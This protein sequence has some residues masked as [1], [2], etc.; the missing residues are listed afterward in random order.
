MELKNGII[1]EE[2]NKKNELYFS[3]KLKE[4][5]LYELIPN[6]YSDK[7]NEL[8]YYNNCQ[9]INE[10]LLNIIRE[11]DKDFL[12]LIKYKKINCIL[13]N[14]KAIILLNNK[15]I[16]I[17]HFDEQNIFVVELLIYSEDS[18]SLKS[19]IFDQIRIHGYNYIN[20]YIR[21]KQINLGNGNIATIQEI[22]KRKPSE[23]YISISN[24]LKALILLSISQLKNNKFLN[25]QNNF[26][27]V[28]LMNINWLNYY[29]YNRIN[30]MII[31]NYKIKDEINK[32][33]YS[34]FFYDLNLINKIH[35]NL[36]LKLLNDIDF[37]INN[38]KNN[39]K[40]QVE[41]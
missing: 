11:I 13:G 31:E 25:N 16:N 29:E 26:E 33:N 3:D 19:K 24:K 1:S 15:I 39:N 10:S 38:N 28:F 34:D 18:N 21:N 27:E 14:K 8:L 5:K 6:Y 36:D 2:L 41:C 7:R 17:G 32:I 22:F 35:L 20:N 9:I 40:F 12:K 4:K 23:D 37:I 30:L